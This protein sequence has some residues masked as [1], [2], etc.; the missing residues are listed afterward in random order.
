MKRLTRHIRDSS[1]ACALTIRSRNL[2]RAQLSFGAMWAGEWAVMVTIGVVAFRDGGAAAVGVV[3]VLRMLPAALLA[4][5]AATVADAIR[6]EHVL[7]GVGF[8]RTLTL[9]A[10]A[11]VIAL[12]GPLPA[13]YSLV[14]VAT[15]PQTLYRP[16]HSALL[17][18][19]CTTPAELTCANMTRGLVDSLAT[20]IGPLAA[21]LLLS[22]SGTAAA[23]AACAAASLLAAL[24]VASLR[25]EAPPRMHG[26]AV[27][28][29]DV[30]DG[31]QAIFAGSRVLLINSVTAGQTFTRGALS[32]LS[33][34]VA[35]DLL[36]TGEPGVG[37]LNG[38]VGAGA[39]LGSI[40][41]LLLLGHGHLARWFGLGVAL[42]G[43]PLAV[44]GAV[45][46]EASAIALLAV[47]GIGNALVDVG[48]F[49]LPARLVD[50]SVMAR[51]FAGF[52][53]ILTLGVAAGAAVAPLAIELLGIRGALVAIGLLARSPRSRLGPRCGGSTPT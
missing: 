14:V 29:R 4:P 12:D 25:Y 15:I 43:L 37:I 47:V 32:V 33:V 3:G 51:V 46:G 49:T 41:V 50:E 39:V 11:A 30:L 26:A 22:L 23:F 42:W 40:L 34:V 9:G 5:F 31:V 6:R 36:R 20:L 24:L 16:A 35:I 18:S 28:L 53:G 44:I 27:G 13:V 7:A 38:A 48:A 19:L 10:S 21:A 1:R 45:P 17:P 8:I 52:E 2:R